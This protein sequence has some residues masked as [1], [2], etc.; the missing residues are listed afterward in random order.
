M[1]DFFLCV[2]RLRD[3]YCWVCVILC[4]EVAWFCVFRGCVILCVESLHDFSHSLRLHNLFFQSLHVLFLRRGWVILL[5]RF[6]HLLC[7]EAA[8]FIVWRGSVT[9]CVK[10]FFFSKKRFFWEKKRSF[11]V[12]KKVFLVFFFGKMFFCG[13]KLLWFFLWKKY[14]FSHYW[15]Y[16]NYCHYCHN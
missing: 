4:G 16:C 7:E 3:S 14:S 2:D 13:K 12:K 5:L 1:H 10:R 8:W 9:L 11:W 15:N 6:P